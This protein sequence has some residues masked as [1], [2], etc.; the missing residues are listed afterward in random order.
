MV[1]LFGEPGHLRIAVRED[2]PIRAGEAFLR[3]SLAIGEPGCRR[4]RDGLIVWVFESDRQANEQF[5]FI[6]LFEKLGSSFRGEGSAVSAIARRR[7]RKPRFR[8]MTA[9]FG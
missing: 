7:I 6:G 1:Q 5:V 2:E 9:S 3:Q 8:E 4:L